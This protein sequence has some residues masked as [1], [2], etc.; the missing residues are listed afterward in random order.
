MEWKEYKICWLL[1]Q[2]KGCIALL[3]S[4]YRQIVHMDSLCA[5]SQADQALTTRRTESTHNKL[6]EFRAKQKVASLRET[7][8]LCFNDICSNVQAQK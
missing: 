3:S 6:S 8:Q 2:D 1:F 7:K 4:N 5:T